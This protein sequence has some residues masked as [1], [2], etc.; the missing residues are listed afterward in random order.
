MKPYFEQDGITIYHGD[1]AELM[2]E[3]PSFDLVVTDPPYGCLFK[4]GHRKAETAYDHI[5]GDDALPLAMIEMAIGMA[6]RAAYVFCRWDNLYEL[7]KPRSVIAWV[8]NG[9]GMGDVKHEHWRLWEACCFYP[10]AGHEFRHRPA[11]VIHADRTGNV[12][13]PTEKPVVLYEAI[14]DANVGDTIFDPFMGSGP[15]LLAA[16]NLGRKATGCDIE[17]KYCEQ[18]A[19]F[20]RNIPV[21]SHADNWRMS[22]W[23]G[24]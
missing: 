2:L 4:S 22:M 15:A 17:E 21:K 24:Q 5:A 7:P 11:D 1:S 18:V 12:Y 3:L 6:T 8:K 13:H 14:I 20:L 10:Q 16:Q 9:G 19:N 23:E